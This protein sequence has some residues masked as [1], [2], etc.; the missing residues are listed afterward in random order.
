MW[1]KYN[2]KLRY[3]YYVRDTWYIIVPADILGLDYEEENL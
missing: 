2:I 1:Y 3:N